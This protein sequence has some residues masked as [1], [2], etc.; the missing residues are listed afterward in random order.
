RRDTIGQ[1]L[2]RNLI[3]GDY[4]GVVYAVNPTA[5]AVSG[6]PAYTS[7]TDI[8]DDVDVA[9]VA[10]PSTAVQDVVLERAAKGVQGLVVVSSGF[11]A[12]GAVGRK[13]QRRLVGLARSYGLRLIGPNCLGVINTDTEISLNASLSNVMPARGR[14]GFFCQSGA[15]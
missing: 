13:R 14:A 3:T 4:A 2:V 8:P 11:A 12:T 9:I 1:A 5:E 7:V 6:L 10:V 15:L